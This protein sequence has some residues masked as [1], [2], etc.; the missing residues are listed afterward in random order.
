VRTAGGSTLSDVKGQ[1]GQ[2]VLAVVTA[3]LSL[4][5]FLPALPGACTGIPVGLVLIAVNAPATM[6][7]PPAW[8]LAA[9]T[10]RILAAVA[11][12]TAI[13][14]RLAARAPAAQVLSAEAA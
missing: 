1:E 4:A 13:P 7:L 11:L 5:Q 6:S 14:A 3:A 10:G 2:H 12:L 8:W 9:A